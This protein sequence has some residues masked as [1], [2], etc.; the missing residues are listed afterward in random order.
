M[1]NIRESGPIIPK[2]STLIFSQV[3]EKINATF[4]EISY[5]G[6]L[7]SLSGYPISKGH[8]INP[9]GHDQSLLRFLFQPDQEYT[10]SMQ[11]VR[12]TQR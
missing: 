8:Q 2:T 1:I 11:R 5:P 6:A 4:H 12:M 10:Q 7:Q 9:G 3:S